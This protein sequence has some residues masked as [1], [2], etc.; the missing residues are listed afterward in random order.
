MDGIKTK[1]VESCPFAI[2]QDFLLCTD[3]SPE[4]SDK[5]KADWVEAYV[6]QID[7]MIFAGLWRDRGSRP[8]PPVLMFK[9]TIFQILKKNLS[10][11]KWAR[12]VLSDS[13]L[14][15]LIF[16]ITPSRSALYNF[17]DRIGTILERIDQSLITQ[18]IEY[19]LVVPSAVA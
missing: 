3:A 8:H 15:T 5:E 4:G 12:E 19:K 13:I 11:A 18:S 14:Q 2:L 6:D 7:P 10:P 17:K 16:N 1:A 9:L